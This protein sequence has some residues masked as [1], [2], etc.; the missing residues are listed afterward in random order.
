VGTE[1]AFRHLSMVDIEDNKLSKPFAVSWLMDQRF[2][3]K[4]IPTDKKHGFVN[5]SEDKEKSQ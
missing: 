1:L 2:R 4:E 5:T 3:V